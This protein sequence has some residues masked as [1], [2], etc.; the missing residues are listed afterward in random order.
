MN[1]SD[2]DLITHMRILVRTI[3]LE[4]ICLTAAPTSAP[5]RGCM[6]ATSPNSPP[7]PPTSSLGPPGL[8]LGRRSCRLAPRPDCSGGPPHTLNSRWAIG[9]VGHLAIW[10]GGR[11]SS[12]IAFSSRV[13]PA[14]TWNSL[15]IRH[16]LEAYPQLV[17]VSPLTQT[18]LAYS[19]FL[20][21]HSC[22][23]YTKIFLELKQDTHISR[24]LSNISQLQVTCSNSMLFTTIFHF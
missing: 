1:K 14:K 23:K 17:G 11:T 22:Y 7:H 3:G 13:V 8:P 5:L 15:Y 6:A 19:G 24:A 4:L 12:E 20:R 10:T 18:Y 21:H 2:E 16:I 9:G